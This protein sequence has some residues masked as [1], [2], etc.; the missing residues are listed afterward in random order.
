MRRFFRKTQ[1]LLLASVVALLLVSGC[2][3]QHPRA[4]LGSNPEASEGATSLGKKVTG[5]GSTTGTSSTLVERN[6]ILN[7]ALM[8]VED[9]AVSQLVKASTGGT[10]YF[11]EFKFYVPPGSLVKDTVIGITMTSDKYIKMDFSPNGTQFNPPA[12]MTVTYATANLSKTLPSKL[13]ISWFDT[14]TNQWINLGGT[15]DQ[16]KLTVSVPVSHF[17]EYS[18]STR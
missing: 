10:L 1:M 8:Q 7:L 15:V 16:S 11:G 13:S 18:L 17:T 3:E 12:T 14:A 2:S 9:L 5:P 4:P 6:T